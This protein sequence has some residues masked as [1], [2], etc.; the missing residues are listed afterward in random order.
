[1]GTKQRSFRRVASMAIAGLVMISSL[2]SCI[3]MTHGWRR[4]R[5][6]RDSRTYH[7]RRH[8]DHWNR[9]MGDSAFRSEASR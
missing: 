6:D 3:V 8:D 1:M 7:E 2:S 4:E 5:W 9:N